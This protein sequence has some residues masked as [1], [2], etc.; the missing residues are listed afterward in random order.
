MNG[1]VK[2]RSFKMLKVIILISLLFLITVII[3]LQFKAEF[4]KNEI[5]QHYG[6]YI[7]RKRISYKP[8]FVFYLESKALKNSYYNIYWDTINLPYEENELFGKNY[9]LWFNI[10]YNAYLMYCFYDRKE[11]ELYQIQKKK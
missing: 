10:Q 4:Y 8:F 6:F 1:K 5:N 7:K 9:T 11:L 2:H 3:G